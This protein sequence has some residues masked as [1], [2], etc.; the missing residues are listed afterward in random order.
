VGAGR[1][2]NDPHWADGRPPN[3][4]HLDVKKTTRKMPHYMAMFVCDLFIV[5]LK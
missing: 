3:D 4:A 5:Y 2:P 1:P